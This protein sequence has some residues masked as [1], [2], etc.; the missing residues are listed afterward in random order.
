MTIKWIP[1]LLSKLSSFRSSVLWPLLSW[2][3]SI[4]ESFDRELITMTWIFFL[5]L[6]KNTL[7][8]DETNIVW[9]NEL[10]N[11]LRK[12]P[13]LSFIPLEKRQIFTTIS[14]FLNNIVNDIITAYIIIIFMWRKSLNV[15]FVCIEKEVW[16]ALE[17]EI[18]WCNRWK[19]VAI[20]TSM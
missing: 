11:Y 4:F 14:L 13:S 10:L 19:C 15:W 16:L 8:I 3:L 17:K 2:W 18:S 1:Y 12:Q 6:N 7:V 20:V 9:W 5:V